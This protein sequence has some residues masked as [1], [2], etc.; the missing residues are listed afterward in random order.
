MKKYNQCR[1][2]HVS[3][4][5]TVVRKTTNTERFRLKLLYPYYTLLVKSVPLQAHLFKKQTN[6]SII[7]EKT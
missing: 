1:N 2:T 3:T 4:I 7:G 6:G 5:A